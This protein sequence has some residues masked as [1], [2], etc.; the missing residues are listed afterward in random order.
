MVAP[1]VLTTSGPTLTPTPDARVVRLVSDHR[2]MD[3]GVWPVLP[4]TERDQWVYLPGR[5]L[6]PLR[7]DMHREEVI[8]ALAAH[9]FTTQPDGYS[10]GWDPVRFVKEG[11]PLRQAS[12]D[13]YFYTDGEL[14]YVQVDGRLGPQVTCEGIQLIGRVPSELA[15]EM[16]AHA[17]RYDTGLRGSLTGDFF[18]DGFQLEL[19]AQR[20]GDRVVSWALFFVS[21]D[22]HSNTRD[23]AP[24]T[25]WHRW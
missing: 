19:G 7:M 23:N 8:A 13:C 16:E 18:C 2:A 5:T 25:V 10:P 14:A 24:R 12:V 15:Q 20:V 1:Q 6:G 11:A 21:G 9:G 4:D 17:T 22:D 3:M